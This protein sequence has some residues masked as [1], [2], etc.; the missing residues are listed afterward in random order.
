M[1]RMSSVNDKAGML[2]QQRGLLRY[3]F[4]CT[5]AVRLLFGLVAGCCCLGTHCL[6]LTVGSRQIIA[7]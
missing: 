5:L 7:L 1:L 4:Y 2:I 6:M 3:L